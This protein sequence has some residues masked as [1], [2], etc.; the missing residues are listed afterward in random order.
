MKFYEF[1]GS[2]NFDYYALIGAESEEQAI[3]TYHHDICDKDP[4]EGFPDE[5]SKE[6]SLLKYIETC[7]QEKVA[8]I[9]VKI[10]E[11]KQKAKDSTPY[12]FLIDGSLI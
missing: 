12:V 8:D 9:N 10:K 5:I 2:N 4:N 1:N 11:F 6:K 7:K 3:K